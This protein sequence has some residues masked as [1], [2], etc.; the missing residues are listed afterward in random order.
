MRILILGGNGFIGK[1]LGH[2]LSRKGHTIISFDLEKIFKDTKH[3][4]YVQGNFFDDEDFI[5]YLKNVDIVYHA[6]S[7]INPGN[8]NDK[9]MQGYM[10]DFLQSIKLC[11]YSREYNFRI[12][13]LSSGGTVYG[14][15][16]TLP[17]KEETIST[18]INHYGNLKL[19][20]ENTY[21]TFNKQFGTDIV[22][23]R[24][25][26]PYGPGQDYSKGVGFI[27]A[28]L[29]RALKHESIEIW[30]DGSIIRDYIYINDVCHMLYSLLDYKGSD[31]VFNISSNCGSSQND[32]INIL[33]NLIPD[34]SVKYLPARPV[35]VPAIVLDNSKIL[36]LCKER[37]LEIDEGIEKY[38]NFLV[39]KEAN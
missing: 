24:I 3:I 18:P 26:N 25:A 19:C 31:P 16:E 34:I 17:I 22:I 12:I 36:S 39:K 5:P 8:S 37:C 32:I 29:K 20:I 1:N 14:Y 38:Y 9:Y 10:Y 28:A 15:Q 21:R 13:Y 7:T 6:I 23:A 4:K 11:D 30:G 33:Q 2:Y 35:D 27:D